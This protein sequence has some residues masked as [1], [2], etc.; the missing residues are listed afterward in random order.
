MFLV[1]MS[2]LLIYGLF[3]GIVITSHYVKDKVVPIKHYSIKTYGG[4]DV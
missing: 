4:V 2:V 3:N 1:N